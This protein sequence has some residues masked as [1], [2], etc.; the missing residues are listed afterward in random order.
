MKSFTL[1]NLCNSEASLT[2]YLH[3]PDTMHIHRGK[4]PAVLVI[5]GGGYEKWVERE[6]DPV[7]F[8]FYS[9][10]FNAFVLKYT[11]FDPCKPNEFLRLKPLKQ[12]A[13]AIRQIRMHS[14]EWNTNEKLAV[15]GFSAGGH[16]AGCCETLWN[17]PE[18]KRIILDETVN[19]RPD[20]AVL[21]Y[22]V[23]LCGKKA[24]RPS[25]HHLVGNEDATFFNVAEHVT[26]D[27][28]PTFIWTTVEDELVPCENSLEMANALQR[29]G[30]PY[31]LH[32]YAHGR[33]GLTLGKMETNESHPHLAT[34]V[35]LCKEWLGDIFDF[36]VSI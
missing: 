34:W 16:L 2:A 22:P 30:V 14:A 3:D 31:E 33:H 8:E 29:N 15:I 24:H 6:A 18:F 5:P 10:G 21:C 7:A 23:I 17:T 28:P 36:P 20:A 11:V 26:S 4:R 1:A 19:Y 32:M 25:I 35:N 12:A 27:T 13:E 9:A